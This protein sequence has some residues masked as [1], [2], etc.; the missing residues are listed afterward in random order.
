MHTA[1]LFAFMLLLT[2]PLAGGPLD[3]LQANFQTRCDFAEA[4]RDLQLKKLDASYL[5]AL[6]RQV[7]KTRATGK[8]DAVIPLIEEVQAVKAG[9]DPLPEL[10]EA[11]SLE[12]KQMRGK[13]AEA[14]AKILK[15]HAE[16]IASLADK[17]EAALKTKETELTKAG[18][19]DDALAAKKMRENLEKDQTIG[20]ARDLLRFGGGSSLGRP[21][22]Q[23]RRY[24]DNLEVLVHYDRSGK[25]SMDSPVSNIR[26]RTDPGRDLGDTKAT[27]LGEFVGA[28][29]YK[30]DPYVSLNESF[31]GSENEKVAAYMMKLNPGF[32]IADRKGAR[33]SFV[34]EAKSSYLHLRN[35]VPPKSVPGA[36]R[37]ETSYFIPKTNHHVHKFVLIQG[38]A[39]GAPLGG[40]TFDQLDQW[41]RTTAESES[42]AESPNVL[43]SFQ[44]HSAVGLPDALN[45]F[46]VLESL[47]IEQIRF[48]AFL[49]KRIDPSGKPIDEITDPTKQALII[50]N[51]ILIGGGAAPPGPPRE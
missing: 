29:G 38:E 46:I 24:G 45:D 22:M 23:I 43:L 25:I 18:K 49:Q 26:E 4:D 6:D 48:S 30:A 5:A 31:D 41:T 10:P 12:L 7:E 8:L 19:F 42:V 14:R 33:L 21:A 17:M 37:I 3:D 34:A 51:G 9:T 35:T 40:V 15:S 39:G 50:R 13:H 28:K 11:A 20:D 44:P 36:F 2:F 16:A 1:H 32:A 47:R 27:T